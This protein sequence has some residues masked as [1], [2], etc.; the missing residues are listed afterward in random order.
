MAYADRTYGDEGANEPDWNLP[1]KEPSEN[2]PDGSLPPWKKDETLDQILER[3]RTDWKT[4]GADYSSIDDYFN[5]LI[6]K[7]HSVLN[8]TPNGKDLIDGSTIEYCGA[9][10]MS[11]GPGEKMIIKL[12]GV[13]VEAIV[14]REL[15]LNVCH[16]RSNVRLEITAS[17]LQRL[18]DVDTVNVYGEVAKALDQGLADYRS[19]KVR[20]R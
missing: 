11:A 17:K 5:A 14:Y 6:K 3:E 13:K 20:Y 8:G 1:D 18:N 4:R 19:V 9:D 7:T 10:G 16:E 15:P 2:E 12:P